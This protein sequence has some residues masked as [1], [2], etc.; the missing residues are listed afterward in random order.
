[1][2]LEEKIAEGAEG[3]VW[4][5]SLLATGTIVAV[6]KS[7]VET[8][9]KVWNE[10]EVA[11]MMSLQHERL[12]QFI[13]AGEAATSPYITL[14]LTRDPQQM[15]DEHNQGNVLFQVEEY[16]SGG[17]LDTRLWGTSFSSVTWGERLQ[18]AC[19]TAEGM[20][21]IHQRGFTH[22]HDASSLM[23]L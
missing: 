5:A 21:A 17:S 23:M 6:K 1:M 15:Y 16:L 3:E 12:V 19:D 20:N 11:F 13:G 8:Q 22:R 2:K 7:K 14:T 18:W 4:R 10:A 9:T